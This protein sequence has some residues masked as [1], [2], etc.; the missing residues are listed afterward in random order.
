[1]F[2]SAPPLEASAAIRDPIGAVLREQGA[3]EQIVHIPNEVSSAQLIEE[4][5][6]GLRAKAL[7]DYQAGKQL[8]TQICYLAC[9]GEIVHAC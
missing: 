6:T 1:M 5:E 4:V 7:Y 9:Q 8:H 3:G 2:I